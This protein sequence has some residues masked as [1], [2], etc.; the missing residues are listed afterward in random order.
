MATP[1]TSE[2]RQGRIDRARTLMATAKID[3]VLLAGSTSTVYFTNVRWWLSE[4]FFGIFL[5]AKGDHF[6]VCPAFEE[7]RAREQLTAGP[8]GDIPVLT[9]H[10]HEDPYA[11]AAKGLRDRGL[12]TG[13]GANGTT[14][15]WQGA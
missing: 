1:I 4:R 11:L 5:T 13:R 6:A 9:W 8:L 14:P 3:A 10:E 15:G 7:E 12:A 2:E